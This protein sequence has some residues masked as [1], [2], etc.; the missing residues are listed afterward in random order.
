MPRG[1]TNLGGI[2]ALSSILLVETIQ[3]FFPQ[4][5][6]KLNVAECPSY[7][8]ESTH[9]P[10]IQRR[11]KIAQLLKEKSQDRDRNTADFVMSAFDAAISWICEF[12]GISP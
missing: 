11:D 6:K 10:T 7:L 8:Q 12:A 2:L 1:L 5:T 9:P 3:K 4:I